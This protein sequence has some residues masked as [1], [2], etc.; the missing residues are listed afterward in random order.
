VRVDR[1]V[2]ESGEYVVSVG[3]SSRDLRS[4]VSVEM[5]GERVMLPA[6]LESSI[7]EL[8]DDPV[9]GEELNAALTEKYGPDSPSVT[10]LGNFPVGRLDGMPLPRA[11]VVELVER[12]QRGS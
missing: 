10:L 1:W 11:E 8:L 3:S 7:E 5:E 4:S 12:A 2:V 6:S 9:V